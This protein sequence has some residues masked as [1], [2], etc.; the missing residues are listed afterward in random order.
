LRRAGAGEVR[1]RT[2]SLVIAEIV[3]VLETVYHLQREVVR[4]RVLAILNTPGLEVGDSDLVLQALAGYA[5]DNID[6]ADAFNGAWM[7]SEGIALAYT[8]DRKHSAR[9]DGIQ[10]QAPA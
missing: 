6:F 7:L 3:W 1:L 8:F 10:A 4:E 5:D 2:S 9:L